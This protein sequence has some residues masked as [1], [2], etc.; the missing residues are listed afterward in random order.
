MTAADDSTGNKMTCDLC[1]I[2]FVPDEM[3]YDSG[4]KQWLCPDCL[5]EQHSCGCSDG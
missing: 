5:A 1:G 3:Q 4:T 2:F